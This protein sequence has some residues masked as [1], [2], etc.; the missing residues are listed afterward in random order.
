MDGTDGAG[1]GLFE[2]DVAE[3]VSWVGDE[4][5]SEEIFDVL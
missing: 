3:F 5:G 2:V 1:V 4:D